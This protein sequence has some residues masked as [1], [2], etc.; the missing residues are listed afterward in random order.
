MDVRGL[1]I[2][3]C[4]GTRHRRTVGAYSG[5][6]ARDPPACLQEGDLPRYSG[7]TVA[8]PADAGSAVR[9]DHLSP[10]FVRS[11]RPACRRSER[12]VRPCVRVA[13]GVANAHVLYGRCRLDLRRVRARLAVLRTDAELRASPG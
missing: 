10:R 13:A 11:E 4:T 2:A 9:R 12:M 6:A 3:R 8:A 7:R 1:R 5:G